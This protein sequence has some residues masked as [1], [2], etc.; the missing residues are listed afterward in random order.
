M[1][2]YDA[3]NGRGAVAPAHHHLRDPLAF[4]NRSDQ[5]LNRKHRDSTTLIAQVLHELMRVVVQ[6]KQAPQTRSYTSKL[7]AGGH[8]AISAKVLEEAGELVEAAGGQPLD[9]EHVVREAADLLYHCWVL[10]AHCDVELGEVEDELRR[11]FGVSGIDEK[12]SRKS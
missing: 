7:L 10:L 11:R 2:F 12:E 8:A 6:R 5:G 9:R 4:V 3:P 1:L